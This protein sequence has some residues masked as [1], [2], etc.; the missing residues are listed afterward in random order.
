MNER[1]KGRPADRRG[2]IEAWVRLSAIAG[3]I[4]PG[5]RVPTRQMAA[6]KFAASVLT[7]QRAYE[8][9]LKEGTLAAG[10]RR[11][12]GTRLADAPPCLSRF[13]VVAEGN[14]QGP[15][16]LARAVRAAAGILGAE[17]GLRFDFVI[18]ERQAPDS[19][20]LARALADARAGR[21]AG[22][23]VPTAFRQHGYHD[24][25]L[26]LQG[27]PTGVFYHLRGDAQASRLALLARSGPDEAFWQ[28]VF[29]DLRAGGATRPAVI[30]PLGPADVDTEAEIRR[31]FRR[32]GLEI[33]PHFFHSSNQFWE[34]SAQLRRIVAWLFDA[35]PGVRPDSLFL[36][37]DNFVPP[38]V[39]ALVETLGETE[40]R[41]VTLVANGNRPG[42]PD[43]PLPVRWHGTDIGATLAGFVDWCAAIRA[44]RRARPPRSVSF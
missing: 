8:S 29:A 13:L 7:A 35:P 38:A 26:D 10:P 36:G 19:P 37:D 34:N 6:G 31:R 14:R 39:A 33:P 2:Q 9:L 30:A 4:K 15:L 25:A 21:Y 41:G 44:G 32:G 3:R 23:F 43:M 22:V 28:S 5:D 40:A 27:V 1:K 11:R 16:S 17:R 20:D 24:P 12:D 18:R 42:L